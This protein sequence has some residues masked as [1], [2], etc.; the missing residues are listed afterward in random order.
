M[1][2]RTRLLTLRASLIA[3]ALVAA[4]GL[5]AL[6]PVS[7]AAIE[8]IDLRE[9]ERVPTSPN[10][11]DPPSVVD[12]LR[13]LPSSPRPTP[14]PSPTPTPTP[15]PSE[16]PAPTPNPM[17]TPPGYDISYPQCGSPYPE[18]YSFAIIG[19]NGGRVYSENPCFGPGD[20]E[21]QLAWAGRDAQIYANTGNPGPEL[22]RYWP[23]GQ[24]E[25]RVCDT[26]DVPGADTLD[27]AYVYG[28]NAAE[29]SY[30]TA[31]EAFID[32][33]WTDDDAD[34]LP[35]DPMWWLDVEDANSWRGDRRLNVAALEGAVAYL[36]S[37][38]AEVGFY[39]T[40]RL[41][42]RITGGTDAFEDLPAWHAGARD[43]DD[44]RDRCD[45]PAF[46]GGE[47]RMVQWIEDGFDANYLCG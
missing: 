10:D 27:C 24:T 6:D 37:M 38:D 18:A 15:R 1:P 33:E 44:A 4:L 29:H 21:S 39:S 31:L 14:E 40:P 9:V 11:S 25:P 32:L 12:L 19:V 7:T 35:D 3:A 36:E 46:T 34:R 47:L 8:P 5:P 20:D 26:D 22:S 43:A 23:H 2:T 17:P 42:N 45:E 30:A 16:T 41:W 28:W 13:D